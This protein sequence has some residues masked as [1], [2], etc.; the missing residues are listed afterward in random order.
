MIKS[1]V[2]I[3]SNSIQFLIAQKVNGMI[4]EIYRES[5]ITELGR[6]IKS[7]AKFS[8]ESM[9][10]TCQALKKICTKSQE[11]SIACSEII[12]TATQASR[13]AVNA[14]DFYSQVEKDLGMKVRIIDSY[15]EAYLS[16]LGSVGDFSGNNYI[17]DVGGASSEITIFSDQKIKYTES[18]NIGS[19]TASDYLQKQ[20]SN[21]IGEVFLGASKEGLLSKSFVGIGGSICS[22]ASLILNQKV[23]N[24]QKVEGLKLNL[25][26]LIGLKENL[27]DM[28]EYEILLK[29]PVLGK[30]SRSI[31]GGLEVFIQFIQNFQVKEIKVSTRGLVHGS[32]ISSLRN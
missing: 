22:L 2:D 20:D 8:E 29:Y 21:K 31:R 11:H 19:V 27:G 6:S 1:V 13:V 15:E 16:A 26:D 25:N 24:Q 12:L 17:V 32:F 23:F 4:E 9:D 14:S 18:L 28:D 7:T 30:R 5:F 10:L 3:G